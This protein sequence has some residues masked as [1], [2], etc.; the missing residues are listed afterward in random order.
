[1]EEKRWRTDKI[2]M[3]G[4]ENSIEVDKLP[5][6]QIIVSKNMYRATERVVQI[7]GMDVVQL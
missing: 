7:N 6:H 2:S 3:K 5:K 4:D 1:M